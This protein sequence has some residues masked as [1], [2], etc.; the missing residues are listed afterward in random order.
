[1]SVRP[2][3]DPAY[4]LLHQQARHPLDALF[5]PRSVAVIGASER[6]GS[7]GRTL[8]WNLISNPFGGT[9]Y[10]VNPK[11]TNVL[12]IRTWP[13]ISA[14]PEPVD[15][16]VIVTP[17]PTVPGV[18]QEC[19]AAGVKGAIII[20]A[21]F[22]ETGEEG[23]RLEQEVLREA[24]KG[25]MR[26]IGPNCLGLMRPTTGLNATFAGAMAR[27]GNVAFISQS[28]AL[29]TAIL[30]WSQRETVGFSAF[31][32]LGSMLDVGWGDLIDYLGN[33]P[34][35]RS[36]LLYMESIGDA[37]AF[38]SAARE[39]ALQKPIIVIKAGRTEQA[40]KAAASHTGTLAGS[41]EVLTA[42]FRRAGV[43]RVDSIADLFYMAEVL[44]KQPR[45]EGR[46]LTLVTN[47]GGPGVLATDALVSGGGELAKPSDKTLA[48]LNSFLPPQWSHGNPVD[49][50][51]DADPERYAKALEAAGADENSDGLL[52]ILTPQDMTEPT[53]TADRLKPYARLGKPVLA[54]WMGGSEV[55]AGERILNDAGIP[56]FGYPDTAARIFNYMWRYSYYLSA[57]YET[58]TLAEES[59]GNAREQARALIDAARS[60]GRT[61]LTE[62]ESKQLLAAY[63]IATVETRLAATED[64]AVSQAEAL[65]YP[66]VVKLH[67]RTISHKTDVGG[68][69]LNLASASQVR[70]A[71][72]GIQRTLH[73]LGQADAFHGVTVQPMVRLDGY[74]LIVGSS[75]DA[76]FGPVLLFGAGGILVEVFQDRALGL[77]PLNTTLA[78]RLMERTRIYKA[79]QGVRGRPPVDLAALEKLL[80]RFSKLVVE[81]RLIQEVDI[82]PL[83]AS[84]ERLLALDARVVLH[85]PGVPES[86]LP[87]LAIH[88]YPYQ[89]EGRLR[90]KDGAELIVRPIRPEDEPKMEAFHHA[91]SEQSVFMRYAGMMRLDQRVA[92]ERL[93]RICFIDYAREMALLAVNPTPEGGEI[94][95]V[96]RLTRLPGTGDGE[97]AMLISDRMQYQGLGTE[98]LQRLVAIGREWGL[99]RIV[100][101]ILSRNTPMQRVCR[102]LG[103]DIIADPD[104]TEEMVRAV[105]V[106]V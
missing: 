53:Q 37:R 7:V 65:G 85:E 49:I 14:I 47:A 73:G 33:D 92:H 57:L 34:R 77:P 97:F 19:V 35:T 93:A 13:S 101:D 50:L 98:I 17:A 29:L 86:S 78:R 16:A 66:V 51:G 39:V 90:T 75:L 95:G 8:L 103:F 24:R 72:S 6:Q 52:V 61:L 3:L 80:V 44:A 83:L 22:K 82:N 32:S 46:R 11:R 100:A 21:G 45:P 30:D 84:A 1:M 60:E 55:A 56:T 54:S 69:R 23:A 12:G 99:E 48:A 70:E 28:G 67:S 62:Y 15:L 38:L 88:P 71:F 20:S 4:D 2:P 27:P 94:V 5:A 64:E 76:Q 9:V 91:L 87:P 40:A 74:E 104:P 63:G 59:T 89:Y 42:A 58:P 105:K 41:D 10:P 31:V 43:L 96:G 102:K 68:V 18:I 25:R 36:I 79:L 106:L 26:I 81:Q